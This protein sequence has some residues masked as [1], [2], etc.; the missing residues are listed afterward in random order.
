MAFFFIFLFALHCQKTRFQLRFFQHFSVEILSKY[1]SKTTP[2]FGSAHTT[3][4]GCCF[5]L[6]FWHFFDTKMFN[7]SFD[8]I[9]T[10]FSTLRFLTFL[11]RPFRHIFDTLFLTK[12]LSTVVPLGRSKK[13]FLFD[14]ERYDL[15]NGK[16]WVFK[17]WW[18][19]RHRS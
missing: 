15:T 10:F 3:K 6:L 16:E 8:T 14:F 18:T 19:F 12:I 1:V 17:I 13:N 4:T 7:I 11:S 5:L 9:L 2:L